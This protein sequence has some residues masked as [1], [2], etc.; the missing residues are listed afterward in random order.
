MEDGRQ[1]LVEGEH[2]LALAQLLGG[3]GAQGME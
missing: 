1:L 3:D 2:L